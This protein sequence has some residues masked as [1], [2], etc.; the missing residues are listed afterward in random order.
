[1]WC[2]WY[3]NLAGPVDEG[4]LEPLHEVLLLGRR[5]EVAQLL[6]RDEQHG[7]ALD[8]IRCLGERS[9]ELVEL[10][11]EFL[12]EALRPQ[13][14]VQKCWHVQRVHPPQQRLDRG[15]AHG[16]VVHG[17]VNV[18]G[19]HALVWVTQEKHDFLVNAIKLRDIRRHLKTASLL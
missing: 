11:R 2:V 6:G 14:V 3:W 5:L 10:P 12:L 16:A 9:H 19:N 13:L 7:V 17:C 8:V 1:M 15:T 18:L 4:G